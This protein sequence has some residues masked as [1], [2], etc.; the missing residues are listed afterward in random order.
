MTPSPPT[1]RFALLRHPKPA[2]APGLCYGRSDLGLAP[3]GHAAIAPIVADLAHFAPTAIFTS[4][5]LRCRLLADAIGAAHHLA[6][7]IDP[8]LHEI[9][10]GS[11]EGRAWDDI[12][13]ADLDR[14]AADPFGFAPPGG[15]SGAAVLARVSTFA[16]QLRDSEGTIVI[17]SHGGPLKLLIPLLRGDPPDLLAHAPPQGSITFIPPRPTAG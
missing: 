13:R 3:E 11:W 17:V 16:T 10:F 15:E 6:P 7:R 12:P 14:W 9:D 5:A 8:L 1:P 4:P 2:I